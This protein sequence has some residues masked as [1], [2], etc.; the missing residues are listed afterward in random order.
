MVGT[1]K[2]FQ[3]FENTKTG[4]FVFALLVLFTFIG[5]LLVGAVVFFWNHF[6]KDWVTDEVG[7]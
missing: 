6:L 3:F 2:Y 1:E 7:A 4:K 5:M